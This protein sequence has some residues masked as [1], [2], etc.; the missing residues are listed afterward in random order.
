M[1]TAIRLFE[2]ADGV[3]LVGDWLLPTSSNA[4]EAVTV[5]A[6]GGGIPARRYQRMAQYL[7][8]QGIAVLTFDYRGIGKSRS[9]GL[10]GFG[11]GIDQWGRLDSG[12]ALALAA[13]TYPDARLTVVAHS[14]GLF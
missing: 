7:A 12:A 9:T 6:C 1:G 10:R 5:I 2:A 14:I 3:V 8:G 13:R 4:I 11:A